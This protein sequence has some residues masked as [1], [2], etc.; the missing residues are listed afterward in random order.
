MQRISLQSE[1]LYKALALYEYLKQTD[2]TFEDL[3]LFLLAQGFF[4]RE[5]IF[6]EPVKSFAKFCPECS[7]GMGVFPVNYSKCTQVGGDFKSQWFCPC[8]YDKFSTKTVQEELSSLTE[9][10]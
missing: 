1:D 3:K 5:N 6:Q 10:K 2:Q 7:Q 9:V 8:G 4:G